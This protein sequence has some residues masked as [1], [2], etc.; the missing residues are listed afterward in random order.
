[1]LLNI[2]TC[3]VAILSFQMV[4]QPVEP[5]SLMDLIVLWVPGGCASWQMTIWTEGTAPLDFTES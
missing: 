3:N 1:M 4:S 2:L 5:M